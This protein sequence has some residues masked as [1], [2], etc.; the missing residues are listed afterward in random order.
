MQRKA[1]TIAFQRET[2]EPL[3]I[4]RK[5]LSRSLSFISEASRFPILW[6]AACI[7]IAGT[8]CPFAGVCV[9]TRN[10]RAILSTR[11][12]R[13]RERR[14]ETIQRSNAHRERTRLRGA[15]GSLFSAR[16]G[17][18]SARADHLAAGR[19]HAIAGSDGC[20]IRGLGTCDFSFELAA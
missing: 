12:L 11:V 15:I 16:Y 7:S 14:R 20:G 6:R 5:I 18:S 4:H 19:E 1:E 17:R 10:A 9:P 3:R 13:R 2:N 8:L